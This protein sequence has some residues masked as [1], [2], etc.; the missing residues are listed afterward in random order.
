MKPG[1]LILINL[2]YNMSIEGVAGAQD[3]DWGHVGAQGAG[4]VSHR[5]LGASP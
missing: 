3:G 4:V 2:M 5:G 1:F